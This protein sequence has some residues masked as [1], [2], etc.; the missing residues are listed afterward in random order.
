MFVL[1]RFFANPSEY[2]TDCRYELTI[3]ENMSYSAYSKESPFILIGLTNIFL[4]FL[5]SIDL[6]N[7]TIVTYEQII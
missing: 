6:F 5:V 1:K 7:V 3:F 2:N 4:V